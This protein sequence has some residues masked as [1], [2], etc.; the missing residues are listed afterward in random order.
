MKSTS[1]A[2]FCGVV[3]LLTSLL[4]SHSA[5]AQTK[6]PT[7][8][9]KPGRYIRIA[10]SPQGATVYLDSLE[11]RPIGKTPIKAIR[12]TYGFHEFYFKKKGYK[13]EKLEENVDRYTR[14]V[15]AELVQV[16]TLDITPGNPMAEGGEVSVD[17]EAKGVLPQKLVVEPGRHQ[18][19]VK[20]EGAQTFSQWVECAAAAVVTLPVLLVGED[21][22][23]GTL[24]VTSDVPGAAVFVDGVNR[25]ESPIS[26]DVEPGPLMVEV[27]A[28]GF[29]PWQ[30]TVE[31][32]ADEKSIVQAQIRPE[33]GPAGTLMV[34]SNVSNTTI[35]VD[36]KEIG[37][38]PA[39]VADLVPGTHVIEAKSEGY[40]TKQATAKIAAGEQT[41][42]K[43][44][45]M[46]EEAAFGQINVRSSVP[47]AL[48][49][50]DGGEQGPAP[51]ELSQVSLGPHAIVVRADGHQ[52]YTA[53]CEV[54]RNQ[55][56]NVMA[57]LKALTQVRVTANA[58]NG[59]LIV[60]GKEMGPVP[61]QLTLPVGDHVFRV[62]AKG[63]DP[64]E[65]RVTLQAGLALREIEVFLES[66][67][68]TPDE[69]E[70]N[71]LAAKEAKRR[72]E[73]KRLEGHSGA[74]S[75]S[76]VP[77]APGYNTF[78]IG[79]GIP[80]LLDVRATVGLHHLVDLGVGIRGFGR[81]RPLANVD[82]TPAPGFW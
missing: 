68:P 72:K 35:F 12:V 76:G 8:R 60:N 78:E 56:C 29:D 34:L 25:G 51:V 59:R 77:I 69:L 22:P 80:Y 13:L 42:I 65:Q 20:K 45:L 16:C 64:G 3:F 75:Y 26:L 1:I 50:V 32:K 81:G 44:E 7:R 43:L 33:S 5:S 82:R 66:D 21:V 55:Q 40:A 24:F 62:E 52:D 58:K 28:P 46:V 53:T 67:G 38:A 39:T 19:E 18:V 54:K 6:P 23:M 70:A 2:S 37:L 10:S 17:G 11:K 74:S 15:K 9:L 71:A 61:I 30:K 41:V 36:G 63:Y 79:L 57:N 48:V 14:F 49:Y 27:R 31:V 73:L 4:G 47:G